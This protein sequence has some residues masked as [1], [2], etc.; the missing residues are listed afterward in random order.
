MFME[1]RYVKGDS[2]FRLENLLHIDYNE[3]DLSKHIF[4]ANL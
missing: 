1:N 4:K 2:R 3:K